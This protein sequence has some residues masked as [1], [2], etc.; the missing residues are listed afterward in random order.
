MGSGFRSREIG[1]D[2]ERLVRI[3][4]LF[5]IPTRFDQSIAAKFAEELRT[6]HYILLYHILFLDTIYLNNNRH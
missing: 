6:C 1:P 2:L 5:S 4:P 3:S